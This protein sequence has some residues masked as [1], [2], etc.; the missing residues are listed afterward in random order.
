MAPVNARIAG[1]RRYPRL[2]PVQFR[3]RI[4]SVTPAD[5]AGPSR[6]GPVVRVRHEVAHLLWLQG[7]SVGEIALL[8]HRDHSTVSYAVSKGNAIGRV[9]LPTAAAAPVRR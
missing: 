8:L 4:L 2:S 1:L 7:L 5:V 9:T 6:T 3:R